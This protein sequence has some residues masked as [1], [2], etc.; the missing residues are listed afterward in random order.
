MTGWSLVT[1]RPLGDEG[2]GVS[3]AGVRFE[4]GTLVA[5]PELAAYPG[6]LEVVQDWDHVA[7]AL[8]TASLDKSPVVERYV[9]DLPLRYPRKVLCSGPNYADHLAEMGENFGAEWR[10]YFFLKPPTTSLVMDGAPIL[11]S[12]AP[13]DKVDWEGELAVVIGRG[14][15]DIPP[16]KA[17]DH[18]GGY[19]VVNDIS[20]RGPHR[21]RDVPAPFV[22]D[23]L[24]SKGADTSLPIAF[25]VVPAWHIDDPQ[26]LLVQTRV[27]GDLVQAAS[28]SLM[29]CTVAELVSAASE[30]VTLEPGDLIATG[31]PSGVGAGRGVFLSA[32]DEV[33]VTIV[34]VGRVCNPVRVRE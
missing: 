18:V 7:R 11:I 24:A 29:V 20:L 3:R 10:P 32:G 16:E 12:G 6:V 30:L 9:L 2:G 26:D 34:G 17:L 4:E 19:T 21:R 33:E 27:N 22:W 14:G 23:W 8:R 31:T 1:Y 25:D 13:D 15:R 5:P 28:T